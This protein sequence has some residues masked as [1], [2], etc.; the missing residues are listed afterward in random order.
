ME[1]KDQAS[2]NE[3]MRIAMNAK[4]HVELRDREGNRIVLK[5]MLSRYIAL[6][7]LLN[8]HGNELELFCENREDEAMFME[9]LK[10]GKLEP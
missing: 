1:L 6:D 5:S 7:K 4:G 10:D 9:L 3:F 2:A 8:E